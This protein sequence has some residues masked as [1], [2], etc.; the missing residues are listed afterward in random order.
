MPNTENGTTK[1]HVNGFLSTADFAGPYDVIVVGGGAAGI[2]AAIGAKQ[3]VPQSRV[4]LI[5][6]EACLGGA[7]THRGVLSYCGLYSVGP[8]PR[9]AVGK[10]WTELHARLVLEGAATPLPDRVVAYV[11]ARRKFYIPRNSKLTPSFQH[12]DPEGLKH[13]LDDMVASYDIEVLLHCAVVGGDRTDGKL[14]TVEVQERRGRRTISGKAFVDCSGDGDLASHAGASTRYGNHGHVNMGSLATRFGGL[15]NASPSS[16]LWRDAIQQAKAAD[17][18]LKKTIPRNVGVLIQLPGSGDICTY[19]ASA[20]YDA[21]NSASISSAERQGRMQAKTYLDILRK[22][23]GHEKMY[24]VSS[25]PNF[26]TRESR[27]INSRYQLTESDIFEGRSFEDTV[28]LGAWYTEYHD[29]SKEDWPIIFREPPE[30]V[31]D[32]PLRSLQSLDTSNLFCAGRCADGDQAAAS[33]IRVM[34]TALAT[35]QAAGTAAALTAQT[36]CEADPQDVRLSLL[37]QGALLDRH[38]LVKA[39]YVEEPEGLNITR[40]EALNRH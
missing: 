28:A 7:A 21:R 24:L 30:G 35:G 8:D 38:N 2:G 13:V 27:H 14:V 6:S 34:G 3:T 12:I 22:L 19:M 29:G 18:T 17:P 33:A 37:K 1:V 11:Q 20:I 40:E 26:G 16:S 4:L 39:P 9:R 36:G 15:Q 23:P 31:F 25:G 10:I 32:I 5:E